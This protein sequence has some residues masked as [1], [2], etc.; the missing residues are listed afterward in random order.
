MKKFMILCGLVVT[1]TAC[2][3]NPTTVTRSVDSRPSIVV[4]G[5]PYGATFSIDGVAI[6][7]VDDDKAVLVEP[8]THVVR[9]YSRDGTLLHKE[10]VY[11]GGSTL[12]EIRLPGS[13]L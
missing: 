10:K 6:G 13:K 12:R 5:A 8:G 1:L 9:V 4:M 11:T 7:N 3:Q 2:N